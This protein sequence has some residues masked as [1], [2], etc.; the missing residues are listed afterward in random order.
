MSAASAVLA[1][2]HQMSLFRLTHLLRELHQIA[3]APWRAWRQRRPVTLSLKAPSPGCIQLLAEIRVL[4]G[5]S[6]LR[7]LEPSHDLECVQPQCGMLSDVLEQLAN[8]G[9]G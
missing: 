1:D 8:K 3:P 7:R 5:R 4:L 6:L 2:A 9:L